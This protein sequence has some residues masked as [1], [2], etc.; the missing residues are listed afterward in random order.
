ML[1]FSLA[2]MLYLF[3]NSCIINYATLWIE[4]QSIPLLW[5]SIKMHR[6]S[7]F[8]SD[9][10]PIYKLYCIGYRVIQR[11]RFSSCF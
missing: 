9:C 4:L 7:D 6:I 11:V 3:F 2:A 1:V 5:K 10:N 8:D